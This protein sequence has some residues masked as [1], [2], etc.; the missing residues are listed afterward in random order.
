MV[1]SLEKIKSIEDKNLLAGN[2]AMFLKE[3]SIAQEL[4]LA[5]AHPVAA[6]DMRRDLLHW[7]QVGYFFIHKLLNQQHQCLELADEVRLVTEFTA[8]R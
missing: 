5:S 4:F 1:L 6:L 8:V 3:F 7:D 2:V